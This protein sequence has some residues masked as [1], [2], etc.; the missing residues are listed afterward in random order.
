M[1]DSE[2]WDDERVK[3]YIKMYGDPREKKGSQSQLCKDAS[4]FIKPYTVL[5]VGCGIGHL[6]PF[7]FSPGS[8]FGERV[9]MTYTGVDKSPHMLDM[10]RRFFPGETFI[11][12]DATDFD[13]GCEYDNVIS[14][15]LLLHLT[16]EQAMKALACMWRHVAHGGHLVFGM[17]TLGD[18]VQKRPSGL[19]IRN[20]PVL[21]VV[22]MLNA[23]AAD[24]KAKVTWSHQKLVYQ[25]ISE[26][27]YSKD[28]PH[29]ILSH[30]PIARTTL[31]MMERAG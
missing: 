14:I 16:E 22:D 24:E 23:V 6:V 29:K 31:F 7:A 17:E 5:D 15:S 2:L 8:G 1:S 3:R 13:L 20:Q 21:K 26:I 25:T 12:L 19:I 27:I 4:V 30:Q 18:N 10:A 28:L 11:E 9:G